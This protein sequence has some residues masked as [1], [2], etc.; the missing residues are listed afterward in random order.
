MKLRLKTG[1]TVK[2]LTGKDGGKTGKVVQT[3]PKLG[4]I[5]VEGLNVCKRHLRT[6]RRGEK[7][8]VIEFSMPISASNVQIVGED[9]KT[10][11]HKQRN[12]AG[13]TGQG[14]TVDKAS[15]ST[16]EVQKAEDDKE[17]KN[18]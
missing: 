3:F 11:R 9:G 7:G 12:R 4:R 13:G 6:K 2:V 14:A 15:H 17:K 10:R 16:K 8:Q 5:V 1:D 18:V